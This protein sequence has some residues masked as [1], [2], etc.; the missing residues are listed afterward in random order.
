M[1]SRTGEGLPNVLQSQLAKIPPFL[2]TNLSSSRDCL[3][4]S[5]RD[6]CPRI[7]KGK[8]CSSSSLTRDATLASNWVSTSAGK[9]LETGALMLQ[10][11]PRQRSPVPLSLTSTCLPTHI[12]GGSRQPS[13][14]S[15]EP[16]YASIAP[17]WT[18]SCRP[19]SSASPPATAKTLLL[20][21]L[22][23][24]PRRKQRRGWAP[25]SLVRPLQPSPECGF[26][27]LPHQCPL[28]HSWQ[29]ESTMYNQRWTLLQQAD[30]SVQTRLKRS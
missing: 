24:A 13:L 14:H 8:S 9:L 1:P 19:S 15:S 29:A 11:T 28:L 18:M 3:L 2:H 21:L 10:M 12:R 22:L 26:G 6:F 20:L 25:R 27:D 17:R 5:L 4:V 7:I 30:L 16:R 23:P